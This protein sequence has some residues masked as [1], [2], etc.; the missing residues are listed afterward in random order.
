MVFAPTV[1][2]AA[3]GSLSV[4]DDAGTQTALLSG[5]GQTGPSDSLSTLALS[6]GQQ[7]I[8]TTS[9]QQ[10]VTVTNSGDTPLNGITV[11]VTGP[12]MVAN[13]CGTSLAAHSTCALLVAFAPQA[14]GTA[15]G[16][17]M[18]QDTLR[19]QTVTLSG[20]GTAPP[21]GG[22]GSAATLSPLQLDFGAEGVGAASAAQAV[23]VLNNGSTTLSGIT[24]T[25]SP[26]FV[27]TANGCTA[28]LAPGASCTLGIAFAPAVTGAMQGTLQVI[29]TP[30]AAPLS[31]SLAGS[32]ADFQLSV[33]GASSSTVVG[34]T[35]ATYQLLLTPVGA[36]AGQV[37]LV[38]SGAP[39][40]STCVANPGSVT[41][42]GTGATST[43]VVTV[44]TSAQ[45]IA[46]IAPGAGW[47]ERMW[48]G[49][50]MAGCVP[51]WWSGRR[52]GRRLRRHFAAVL[53]GVLCLGMAGC[54]LSIHGGAAASSGTQGSYTVTVGAAVP[55][56]QHTVSL[57]LVV[58]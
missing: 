42:T 21:S 51:L 4:S 49:I 52:W 40:G 48:P 31:I 14:L 29:A 53:L 55:G 9:A 38:C 8:G 3:S 32:G 58:E 25:T 35:A 37:Q 7:Q 13:Q 44:T 43:I 36:S 30:L 17:L 20:T 22:P 50:A 23:T 16:Q 54:G 12:F 19:Q 57:G 28:A 26:E 10:Q 41:M 27:I 45:A 33:Q 5:N 47:P 11:A 46:A 15:T 56:V 34:G 2:G 24:A 1:S 18:V 6:F 39:A